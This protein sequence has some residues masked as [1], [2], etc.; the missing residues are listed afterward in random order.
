MAIDFTGHCAYPREEAQ[1][2]IAFMRRVHP[3]WF[4]DVLALTDALPLGPFGH[5]IALEFGIEA[6]CRFAL[7]VLNKDWL[8]TVRI[9]VEYVYEVFG[10]D[11]LVVTYGTDSIRPPLKAYPAMQ[12]D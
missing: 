12:I 5:E 6:K 9:A 8:D 1:R 7:F 4:G 2:R 10:T 11:D 3:E